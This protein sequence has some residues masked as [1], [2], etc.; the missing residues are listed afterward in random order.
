MRMMKNITKKEG[1]VRRL[2]STDKKLRKAVKQRL[3]GVAIFSDGN[4]GTMRIFYENM[5]G[6]KL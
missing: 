2:F 6:M 5:E 3:K 4:G 1:V